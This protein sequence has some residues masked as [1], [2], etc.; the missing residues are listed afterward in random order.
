MPEIDILCPFLDPEVHDLAL[1]LP[2][3]LTFDETFQGE[4]VNRA[5]PEYAEIPFEPLHYRSNPPEAWHDARTAADLARYFLRCRDSELID[6]GFAIPRLLRAAFMGSMAY[7][8]WWR[9]LL[10]LPLLQ[11]EETLA[12]H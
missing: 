10:V 5:F 6:T 8:A 11:L 3:E 7:V 1:S 4:A 12:H 2:P 9:P